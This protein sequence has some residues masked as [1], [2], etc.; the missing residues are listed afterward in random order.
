MIGSYIIYNLTLLSPLLLFLTNNKN[1]VQFILSLFV[2]S[3]ISILRYDIGWDYNGIV[4]YYDIVSGN[5][6]SIFF[7]EPVL[8]FLCK[9]F[10]NQI[11]GFIFVFAVYSL[12]TLFFLYKTLEYYNILNEGLF[13]FIALGYMFITF[14]QIRQGLAISIFLYSFKFLER[15]N[16]LKYLGCVVLAMNAHFSALII[17]PFY[18]I[19]KI[20]IKPWLYIA[21]I[22][23]MIFLYFLD[24]WVNLRETIFS[25]IPYYSKYSERPDYLLSE[26]AD[27]GIGV[28]FFIC[29]SSLVIFYHKL[30]NNAVVVNAVF[31]GLIVFLFASGN[32]NIYRISNYFSF[33]LIIAIALLLKNTSQNLF[34]VTLVLTSVLW[35][36]CLIYTNQAGCRPYNTIF[37]KE[38]REN[39]L[40]E[41][42]D[43]VL[44]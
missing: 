21:I 28:I 13:I 30:I 6:Y 41:D 5:D 34:K 33:S 38:A 24:F 42:T 32:L 2:I 8:F 25:A 39:K 40:M 16:F 4:E 44:E 11:N 26:K 1:K 14:D 17:L 23:A 15:K 22:F 31:I 35:M 37:S 20:R 9:I 29:I 3:L 19:L 36:Q 18:W 10:E 27:S 12:L 7:K 43:W